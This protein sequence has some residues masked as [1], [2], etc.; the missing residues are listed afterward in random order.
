LD[1]VQ[2]NHNTN[3]N[4][5]SKLLTSLILPDYYKDLLRQSFDKVSFGVCK[6]GLFQISS[7]SKSFNKLTCLHCIVDSFRLGARMGASASTPGN[8]LK[9]SVNL[10]VK[11]LDGE[12][13][14]CVVSVPE[15]WNR[16]GYKGALVYL[17][18]RAGCKL[19]RAE[20]VE[21]TSIKDKL[22]A[23][24]YLL[25]GVVGEEL[26]HE[27]FSEEYFSGEMYLDEGRKLS[28]IMA[29]GTMK[30]TGFISY[31]LG[32]SV[33]KEV[34][35]TDAMGVKGNMVGDGVNLG[36]VWVIQGGKNPSVLLTHQEKHWGDA[37]ALNDVLV[38]I[39]L[40]V[41]KI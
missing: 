12:A 32:L 16:P 38:A 31:F 34:A 17:I 22:E 15:L 11:R 3:H 29:S 1:P 28:K 19:C 4:Q 30:W 14:G 35:R 20:G 13:A 5:T 9:E 6:L 26:G 37:V 18:R 25:V 40:P 36:G 21:L 23:K 24:G 39:G 27:K 8:V 2:Q 41:S 33:A 10:T 7:I